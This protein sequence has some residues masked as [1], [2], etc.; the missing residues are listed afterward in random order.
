MLQ[1]EPSHH[2]NRRPKWPALLALVVVTA[3]LHMAL[4]GGSSVD[5][6]RHMPPQAQVPA[7]QVRS[8][9]LPLAE[10]TVARV[11]VPQPA[12]VPPP[13]LAKPRPPRL[14]IAA[15]PVVVGS[16]AAAP[17]PQLVRD[18]AP[19]P[20]ASLLASVATAESPPA[21]DSEP[22]V[23]RT[24]MPP[25]ATL[26]Y[27][28]RR[29]GFSGSGELHWQPVG[30]RYEL[31]LVGRIAGIDILTQTSLGLLDEAGVAPQR[32]TDRRRRD[33]RAAN[34]QRDKGLITFSGPSTEY[35]LHPGSQDRLSW[36]V[37]LGAVAN[38]EP[39]RAA[40]GGKVV[41]FV[42]GAR[43]DGEV[44]VF[45][46]VANETVRTEAGPVHAVKFTREPRRAYDTHVEVWLD[47]ARFHLP[48]RARLTSAPDGGVFELLLRDMQ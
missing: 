33:T 7:V 23:Y 40:P 9:M 2:P 14:V 38:A 8:V 41:M 25:P 20:E 34:F 22:P 5:S 17:E 43:G 46:H 35:P 28:L 27:E 36:M 1:Q 18:E 30:Q 32:F 48:V 15:A 6:A 39:Q 47:P 12:A 42:V 31:R 44:W 21:G 16:V 13:A 29:G 11:E 3:L 45:R 24:R 4:L 26:R 37:Q 10:V 19:P